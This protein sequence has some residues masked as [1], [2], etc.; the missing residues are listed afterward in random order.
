MQ[1][2]AP[3]RHMVSEEYLTTLKSLVNFS[4][5]RY[6]PV[7]AWGYDFCFCI[8]PRCLVSPTRHA[9][10]MHTQCWAASW[11]QDRTPNRTDC[12]R[13]ISTSVLLLVILSRMWE[14]DL[15]QGA[16]LCTHTY[17]CNHVSYMICAMDA[18]HLCKS[19]SHLDQVFFSFSARCC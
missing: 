3:V 14:R 16:S 2:A 18:C 13:G 17:R 8:M 4:K 1:I 11:N 19:N 12:W 15:F 10:C 5:N 6:P 7:Y 9:L